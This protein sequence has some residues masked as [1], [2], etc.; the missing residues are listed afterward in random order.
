MQAYGKSTSI[1]A[2]INAI[3]VNV[4]TYLIMLVLVL[5]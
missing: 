5:K 4:L 1:C 2:A 3:H